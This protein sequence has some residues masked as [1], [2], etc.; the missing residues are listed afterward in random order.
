MIFERD[1]E[2]LD[3]LETEQKF[4]VIERIARQR[5]EESIYQAGPNQPPEY[6]EYDYAVAVLA[7][8]EEYGIEELAVFKLP[9]RGNDDWRDQC[10]MFRAEATKVSHRF[11][12][13][14]G[15]RNRTVALDAGTKIKISHWLKKMR[16]LV[17]QADVAPE[18]KD[19][20]YA[21]IDDLQTEVDRDRTPVQAVGE[22]FVAVC[23]YL[24]AGAKQLQP[25]ADL[26]QNVCSSLGLAKDSEDTQRRLPKPKDA[27]RIESPKKEKNPFDRDLDDEIP[28]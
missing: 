22:L 12:L 27:K 9:W 7:A 11:L 2:K 23:T 26:L 16:E 18:K 20:L 10:H 25:V 1:L 3:G 6:D 21:L 5:L 24:G 4:S 8:A 19:R 15:A 13:R 17:Q 28:F 14:F